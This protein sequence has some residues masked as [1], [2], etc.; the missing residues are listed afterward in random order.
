MRTSSE[1]K[2]PSTNKIFIFLRLLDQSVREMRRNDPLRMAG[3]TAFFTTFAIPPILIILFQ[4]FSIFLSRKLLGSE[5]MAVLTNTFGKDVATQVRQTTVGFRML[6]RNWYIA[7]PGFLF[8]LFV[9]T[10]TFGVIKNTLDDIWNIKVKERVGI[11]FT[12]GLRA[13]SALIIL[14]TGLLFLASIF[15]D[16][17]KIMAGNNIGKFYPDGARFFKGA[18]NELA[19]VIIV[20]TW[21]IILFRYLANGRPSWRAAVTGGLLTGILFSIGKEVLSLIMRHSNIANI[22]GASASIVLILLFV[23]YSSFILYFGASFIKVYSKKTGDAITPID[24]AY[25][26]R[27]ER[28]E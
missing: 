1:I 6:V 22:Y 9:A 25:S 23:F 27:L 11:L 15:L 26:Y 18:L 13:R 8:L 21:F 19:T 14:A 3:A 4:V 12:L 7:V 17:I 28:L 20:T 5:L 2:K 24:K 16:A 10:T